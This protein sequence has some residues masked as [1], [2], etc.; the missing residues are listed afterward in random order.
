[1]LSPML[2][3][4]ILGDKTDLNTLSSMK[5]SW[6]L[7]LLQGSRS[8]EA[9]QEYKWLCQQMGVWKSRIQSQQ[10]SLGWGNEKAT[11]EISYLKSSFP[12]RCELE[13]V[14]WLERWGRTSLWSRRCLSFRHRLLC[15]EVSMGSSLHNFKFEKQRIQLFRR[16]DAS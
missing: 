15:F 3:H 6:R 2:S 16:S 5:T 9:F 11:S 13:T 14:S 1:M 7:P 10:E 8:R 4:V 12:L